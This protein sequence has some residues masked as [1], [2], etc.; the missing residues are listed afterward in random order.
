[1]LENSH[2]WHALQ[3]IGGECKRK[4]KELTEVE[5]KRRIFR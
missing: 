2:N 3:K 1:M 5:G 4:T